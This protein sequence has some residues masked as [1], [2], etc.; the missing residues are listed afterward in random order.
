MNIR[1]Y[2]PGDLEAVVDIFT[3]AIQV[4]A[5]SHYDSA[6]RLAWAP[7]DPDLTY[8]AT[9]LAAVHT[10][11]AEDGAGLAGFISYEADGHIDL[12]FT[13]P[14]RTRAGVASALYREV[15]SRL[16]ATSVCELFA[17]ASLIAQ[18]FFERH[19]FTVEAEE[20]VERRGV[21]LL[22]YRMRKRIKR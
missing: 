14:H 17:E 13:A 4:G 8:W 6:Q 19:G 1:P 7:L 9:R 10:L 5:A 2:G 20:C 12:M 15:E 22:R 3:T 21:L 11:V 18:P 16:T